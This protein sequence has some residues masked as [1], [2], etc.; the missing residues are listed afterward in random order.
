MLAHLNGSVFYYFNYLHII[1]QPT[2]MDF[3]LDFVEYVKM[4]IKINH[5]H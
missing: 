3:N 1:F 5:D 4:N 2:Q